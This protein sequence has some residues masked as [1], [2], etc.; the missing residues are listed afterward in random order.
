MGRFRDAINGIVGVA[1]V[2]AVPFGIYEKWNSKSP[3]NDAKPQRVVVNTSIRA[4]IASFTANEIRAKEVLNGKNVRFLGRV[5]E[6]K[7]GAFDQPYITVS[8]VLPL[9]KVVSDGAD[10]LA[11]FAQAIMEL[12]NPPGL[13]AHFDS[14]S[15]SILAEWN[16]GAIVELICEDVELLLGA[17]QASKC[18]GSKFVGKQAESHVASVPEGKSAEPPVGT[19]VGH[20]EG[21]QT[22]T[23]RR[24]NGGLEVAVDAEGASAGGGV[25]TGRI[26]GMGL[27]DKEA[28]TITVP[29]VSGDLT[30]QNKEVDDECRF[31][32]QFSGTGAVISV[33]GKCHR[34]AG[35]CAG[36][37][38]DNL[39][40]KIVK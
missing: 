28:N 6:L 3:D 25:C 32:V 33:D 17:L 24:V 40:K 39:K 5:E 13:T 4:I 37:D 9:S 8:E 15:K 7:L 31:I 29:A 10:P 14:E 12:Q 19:W 16:K 30:Q 27:W 38:S 1:I 35:A 34:Y 18:K 21:T 2:I 26:Q 11:V 23:V 22:L 20:T 36:F